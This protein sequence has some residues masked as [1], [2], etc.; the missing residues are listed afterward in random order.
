[1]ARGNRKKRRK[2]KKGAKKSLAKGRD[3]H[4]LNAIQRKA[5]P[6]KDKKKETEKKK[7]RKGI[8]DE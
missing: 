1:M 3:Y 7:C 8:E 6:M 2:V 5:G 4:A